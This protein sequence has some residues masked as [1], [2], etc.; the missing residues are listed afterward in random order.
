MWGMT[1]LN[2]DNFQNIFCQENILTKY[3]LYMHKGILI[4]YNIKRI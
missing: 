2:L 3:G 4:I 1:R